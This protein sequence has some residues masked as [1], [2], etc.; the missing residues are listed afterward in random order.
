MIL[1]ALLLLQLALHYNVEGKQYLVK[2]KDERKQY[3]VE[4]EDGNSVGENSTGQVYE[5]FL[6]IWDS[7][8]TETRS[9]GALQAQQISVLH[10]PVYVFCFCL[11]T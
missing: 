8:L 10:F 11:L 2:T 7:Q 9:L 6:H 1:T 3:L 4:T 5:Y